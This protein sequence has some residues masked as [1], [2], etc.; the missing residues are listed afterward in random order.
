MEEIVLV[1]GCDRTRSWSNVVFLGNHHDAH[2]SFDVCV[3]SEVIGP[4]VNFQF[5]PGDAQGAVLQ[6][7]PVGMV[8]LYAARNN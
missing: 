4:N 3:T 5:S 8:C 1:T 7:G 6:W 2:V